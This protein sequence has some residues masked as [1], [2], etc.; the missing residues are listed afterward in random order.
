MKKELLN[1][2]KN[3]TPIWF[4]RQ[5]GRY[6]PEYKKIRQNKK[7]F[8]DLCFSPKLACEISLQPIKRFDLDFIILFS[9]ILVI[10]HVL[11]QKVTF[12]ENIGPILRPIENISKLTN[13]SKN[14]WINDLSP[15]FETINLLKSKSKK[16]VIGF[17]GSPFTVLTYMIEGGSSK[18]HKKT[19]LNLINNSV[20]I[21]R[22]IELLIEVSSIYLINQIKAGADI[23]KLFDSWAGT[24]DHEHYEKYVIGP[25]KSIIKK[26][27]SVYPQVPVIMFPKGSGEKIEK[28]L[29]KVPCD[30]VSL[31]KDV[32][33][34]ILLLCKKKK[35]T[36]Q[37]NLDPIRLLAGGEQLEKKI[38]EIMKK[39]NKNDH[40]FNLS[41]G[42]YPDTPIKNVEQTIRIIKNYEK[43]TR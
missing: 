12:K 8:L 10:P 19:K 7:T 14:N 39:F 43:L 9:D 37:G 29:T 36:V 24:L 21:D 28:F 20:Q 1:L 42:I 38:I 33:N 34:K 6:L 27:K 41:H 23:I 22:I 40:I 26:V 16:K 13:V 15:I 11:G 5:A 32:S 4:M 17:C 31:D 35:I 30:V 25:N 3:K 2:T 18:D